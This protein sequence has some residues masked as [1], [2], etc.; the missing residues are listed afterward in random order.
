MQT[1]DQATH[2]LVVSIRTVVSDCKADGTVGM[3]LSNL[4]QITPTRGLTCHPAIYH[5]AFEIAAKRAAKGFL[6]E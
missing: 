3:S 4:K 1:L 5:Q 2:I 6:T